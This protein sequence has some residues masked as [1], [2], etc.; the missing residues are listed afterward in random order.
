[1]LNHYACNSPQHLLA[2]RQ[3][4]GGLAT[5]TG[6]MVG[7]YCGLGTLVNPAVAQQLNKQQKRVLLVFLY[8]GA[9]QL[10]TWDPKPGAP[11]GGPFKAIPT[12]VPGL[13]IGELLPHTARQ[14]H[15]LAVVR[16]VNTAEDD[17][18]K[19]AYLMHTGRRR[20]DPVDYPYFGSVAA[21]ALAVESN[22]LPG[23]IVVG[24]ASPGHC[25]AYLGPR[26][27]S[28]NLP[29]G[30]PPANIKRPDSLSEQSEKQRNEFRRMADKRFEMRR[31]TALT[32]AYTQNYDQA[33]VLMQRGDVFDISKESAQDQQRYGSEPFGRHCL[34]ARRLLENGA[35]FVQVSHANYDCHY[36][37]FNAHIER[38]GEFDRPFASLMEDLAQRGMLQSTLVIVMSEF[39]RTPGINPYYGRDHWSKAWS[40]VLGGC[41]IQAG[42]IFGK[43]NDQGT[44][45]VDGQ[46][47][48][49]KLFHTYLRALGVDS[50][51]SFDING[52]AMPMADP[53]SYPIKELLA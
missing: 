23:H 20:N 34:L 49:A 19:G 21:K 40:V 47:D 18:G 22:P 15:R 9:S 41:G 30:E 32:D 31:N 51:A 2:R 4:L 46:V 16:G 43:T 38:L 29:S 37:N 14:M 26:Y 11:T 53:S 50:N 45:V 3:F 24:G 48:H 44:E 25:A 52:R 28:V 10:E 17:H 27:A 39:G 1:M 5:G 42:A 12:T 8:G 35:T 13:H 7:G 6:L 36:E 33:L